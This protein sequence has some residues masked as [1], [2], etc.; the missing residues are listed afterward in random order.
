MV[1]SLEL[2]GCLVGVMALLPEGEWSRPRESTGLITIGCA[3]DNQ[4]NSFLLDRLMTTRYPLG[5]I[6]IE[7]SHQLALRRMALRAEWVPRLQNEEADALTNGEYHAFSKRN[8]IPVDLEKLHFGVLTELLAS[9]EA[10]FKEVEEAKRQARERRLARP[11]ARERK[12]P[13]GE[14]LRD[15][16]PW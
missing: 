6:L 13:K 12:R 4:G 5:L 9:G 11:W 16:D 1:A 7:L 14:A 15:R 2:L 3:T 10:Y 8:R